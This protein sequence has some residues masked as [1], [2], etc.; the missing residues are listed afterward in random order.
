LELNGAYTTAAGNAGGNFRLRATVSADNNSPS[1]AAAGILRAWFRPID[2]LLI[3][4]GVHDNNSFATPGGLDY[5]GGVGSGLGLLV[6]AEP[7]SG[8]LFGFGLL[9][10]TVSTYLLEQTS[11]RFGVRYTLPDVVRIAAN[12][13][14]NY[15]PAATSG[16]L[17]PEH[18]AFNAALGADIYALK[19]AGISQIALDV[20]A[21][22]LDDFMTFGTL[23]IGEKIGWGIGDFSIGI[24][25]IQ[26]LP[27][28]N[29][30]DR[31]KFGLDMLFWTQYANLLGILTPR[32]E[33]GFSL[34]GRL[35]TSTAG[36]EHRAWDG[37]QRAA[38]HDRFT[39]LDAPTAVIINPSV[40]FAIGGGTIA[41]GY[42][43]M[44]QMVPEIT[45]NV[46]Y[47]TFNVGF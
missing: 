26:R 45:R 7:V 4:A 17:I 47:A 32:L 23:E 46:I 41:L 11:F 14:Y 12:F 18:N 3:S 19:V 33:V 27:I 2:I 36:T 6:E 40:A 30:N 29:D 25:S 22:R 10:R 44:M 5:N 20:L 37:L 34:N 1:L 42:S 15:A 31:S 8:L 9:P 39:G 24:R 13:A 43:F 35:N 38:A 21:L 16:M 28:R